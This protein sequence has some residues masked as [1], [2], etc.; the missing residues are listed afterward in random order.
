MG[1]PLL[2][3]LNTRCWLRELSQRHSQAITDPPAAGHG[4]L[5]ASKSS[6]ALRLSLSK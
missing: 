5:E 4:Q 3:E 6:I 2:Y 1:H